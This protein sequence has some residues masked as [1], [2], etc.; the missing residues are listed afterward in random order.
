MILELSFKVYQQNDEFWSNLL[1]F[2]FFF[3]FIF[4]QIF[5]P[6]FGQISPY[7]TI[8][9]WIGPYQTKLS[10]IE[11]IK[12]SM[13]THAIASTVARCIRAN[14]TQV[15]RPNRHT[16]ASLVKL[17]NGPINYTMT[18]TTLPKFSATESR[19]RTQAIWS[20]WGKPWRKKNPNGWFEAY[21]QLQESTMKDWSYNYKEYTI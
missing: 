8:S 4:K 11:K 1:C 17:C 9:N 12:S 5:W 19:F 20:W 21:H 6:I 2:F 18:I 13:D 3:K 16:H 10:H 15:R 7:W 14:P